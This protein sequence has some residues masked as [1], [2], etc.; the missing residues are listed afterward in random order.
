MKKRLIALLL[1]LAVTVSVPGL[2]ERQNAELEKQLAGMKA[3]MRQ[4][5]IA[6]LV[7]RTAD[8]QT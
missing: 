4:E 6:A 7:E 1:T 2:A 3:A 5:E 8:F